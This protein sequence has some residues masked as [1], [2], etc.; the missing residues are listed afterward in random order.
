M[1][2][3]GIIIIDEDDELL[4]VRRTNGDDTSIIVTSEYAEPYDSMKMTCGLKVGPPGGVIGIRFKGKD[5]VKAMV[6][7]NPE[8]TLQSLVLKW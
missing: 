4:T 7:V 6:V 1:G 5:E 3:K 2:T 8:S